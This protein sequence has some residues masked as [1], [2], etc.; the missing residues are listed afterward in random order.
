MP[1]QSILVPLFEL[2]TEFELTVDGRRV[3]VEVREAGMLN[4]PSGKV[5]CADPSWLCSWERL[6]VVPYNSMGVPS[7]G[8][9]W[10][11]GRGA[12]TI[13]QRVTIH[14]SD[15]IVDDN[16]TLTKLTFGRDEITVEFI[17]ALVGRLDSERHTLLTI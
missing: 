4:L 16:Q 2:D 1:D 15:L 14:A 7:K 6:R 5:I 17:A 11:T 8:R 13:R 10:S 3:R 12:I 9:V